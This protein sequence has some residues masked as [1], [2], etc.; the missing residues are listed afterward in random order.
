MGLREASTAIDLGE[1]ATPYNY[2]DMTG[3]VAQ[4]PLWQGKWTVK[5][6]GGVP[7][8]RWGRISWNDDPSEPC[9]QDDAT[10]TRLVVRA[11]AGD[12]DEVL[13]A[14]PY[15]TIQNNQLFCFQEGQYLQ[16]EVT[17]KGNNS[18][19]GGFLSPVLCN[20]T[21]HDHDPEDGPDTGVIYVNQATGSDENNGTTWSDA[22]ATLQKGLAEAQEQYGSKGCPASIWLA[23]GTYRPDEGPGQTS[24][25]RDSTFTVG[26]NVAIYGGFAGSETSLDQRHPVTN[27]T[28]LSGDL[29]EDDAPGLANRTDNAYQVVTVLGAGG[30]PILDGLTITGGY[31]GEWDWRQEVWDYEGAGICCRH[32]APVIRECIIRDNHSVCAAYGQGGGVGCAEG[33]S[34]A[35]INCLIVDNSA[36]YAGGAVYVSSEASARIV[37][38][39]IAGNSFAMQGGQCGGIYSDAPST[40]VVVKNCTV[41]GNSGMQIAPSSTAPTVTYSDVQGGYAGTGNISDDPWFVSGYHLSANSP[42]IDAGDNAALPQ[43]V[44]TDLDGNARFVDDRDVGDTGSGMPPI[45]DMGAYEYVPPCTSPTVDSTTPDRGVQ[46]YSN[47][48]AH[49]PYEGV[50]PVH[51]E[52]V[53]VT[54]TGSGFDSPA[55][56]KLVQAGQEDLV[57]GSVVVV[58]STTITADI[59][60]TGAAPGSLDG[61]WDV[62]VTTCADGTLTSG[63][64]VSMCFAPPQDADGDGDVDL[65]DFGIFQDCFNGPN[66][67]YKLDEA[68]C[69]CMDADHDADIDVADFLV[70]QSCFNGP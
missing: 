9:S 70:F 66:R 47:L 27:E 25:D 18:Q 7:G 31:I 8:G 50:G 45:V 34:P 14:Q 42:C 48:V 68:A 55:T 29:N 49:P 16:I 56:V 30:T 54:I 1:G 37:N 44:T 3:F 39:T 4:Q 13:N 61:S 64:T 60:L 22:V 2:S 32:S 36:S 19:P 5:Y 51:G 33:S 58:D 40:A 57:A 65:G 11:R 21:I 69:Y 43:A 62:V 67:S 59:D 41:W 35:L 26:P 52:A 63:F 12:S 6:D 10:L 53:H 38:C 17:F 28:I 24:G 46:D 23:K 20:L 15:V